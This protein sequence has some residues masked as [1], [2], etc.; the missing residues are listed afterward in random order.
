VIPP[1][2][3]ALKDVGVREVSVS[4][5]NFE[6]APVVIR[7][8]VSASGPMARPSSPP[9]STSRAR[10]SPRQELKATSDGK[11]LG[12]RFQ[13][14]P[15]KKGINF[16]RVVAFTALS[17]SPEKKGVIDEARSGEQTLANN[18]RLVVVD[19]GGGPY[20]CSTRR[21]ANWE[22]K[23]LRRALQEDEQVNLVGLLRIA[24]AR[25]SSNS[26]RP[27][28]AGPRPSTTASTPTPTP[29]RPPTSRSSSASYRGRGRASRRFPQD[30]RRALPLHAIIIDDL[31]ASFFTQDQL[32]LLRNF[33]SR[34]GGGLLMLGGPDSF[35][36]G[37][38]DRT[39]VG[40]MLPVYL[41]KL[42]LA[43]PSQAATDYRL[44][45][46]REGWLQPWCGPARPRKKKSSG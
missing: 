24:N 7:A 36:D 46:T 17:E 22:F 2:R 13:F 41:N 18:T 34:R 30:R 6:S 15:E 37:K 45:L 29:L 44:V 23:F 9:C 4:Q 5:T 27:A 21:S 39:P 12:Y 11:P 38:Y 43:P 19:Q 3:H 40:E 32:A 26:R 31:E 20:G 14:R 8:D 33:V 28:R 25:R 16:Y 1:S 42:A 10:R 35:S